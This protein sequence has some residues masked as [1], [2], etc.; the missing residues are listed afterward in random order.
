MVASSHPAVTAAAVDVLRSGG[1]AV[2]AMVT[3]VLLQQVVE[4]QLSTLAG[5]FGMLHWDASR[6]SATYLNAAP[7]HPVGGTTAGRGLPDTSGEHVAVPGAVR[8]LRAAVDR[9]GVQPW[10]AH[11]GP[12]VAA[13][14]GG[15]AVY[16]QLH[17][18]LRA[19]EARVTHHPSGRAR[20]A[21]DGQLPEV[22]QPFRQP[23]LAA[24]LR[25]LAAADGVEW[26][27]DGPFAERFVAAVRSSGGTVRRSD[28]ARYEPRWSEPLSF[29][30]RGHRVLAPPPPDVGGL[31]CAFALGVLEHAGIDRLGP[32]LTSPAALALIARAQDAAE[33]HVDRYGADPL[34][35][36]V[37]VEVLLSPDYLRLT[38]RLLTGSGPRPTTADPA[39]MGSNQLVIVDAAG[40]WVCMLHTG[41]GTDFGTGLVVDGVGVNAAGLFPGV[42][43]GRGRRVVAP[44]SSVLVLRDGT[45]WVGLGTPGFPAP[46]TTLVLLDLLEYGMGVA[47][48][49]DAPRFAFDLDARG[50]LAVEARVPHPT[51]DGLAELG[52]TTRLLADHD[53]ATGRFQAV[54]RDGDRLVGVV[55]P[56]GSGAA[57][58]YS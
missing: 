2:D 21:P 44:L 55:D 10:G 47:E 22:G 36:D 40:N 58:G 29:R 16:D 51:L 20:Y 49:V 5:G 7:D 15:F 25:R 39:A 42:G 52:I 31:Y 19:A 27:Q 48:A 35:F 41:Y 24:T 37:P 56:R 6:G 12:A 4:P 45:P 28:L 50:P 11:F 46:Y 17:R 32:W 33:A 57:A 34:A 18:A 43:T 53:R 23:E 30:Y 9:F 1:T 13:A 54:A 26:F 3:T 38:A 8:G 14:E